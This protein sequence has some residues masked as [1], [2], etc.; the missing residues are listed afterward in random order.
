[1]KEKKR[2]PCN[3]AKGYRPKQHVFL[4]RRQTFLGRLKA[5]ALEVGDLRFDA[6]GDAIVD[7]VLAGRK[8][9]GM[10]CFDV[11]LDPK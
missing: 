11:A 6:R 7:F 1:M 9:G 10:E 5:A 8:V 2:P 3:H 4:D